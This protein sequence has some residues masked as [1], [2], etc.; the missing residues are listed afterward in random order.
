M[1]LTGSHLGRLS[2]CR[3]AA[4]S[5]AA[6]AAGS[7]ARPSSSQSLLA[8]GSRR[9][10]P[11]RLAPAR[12]GGGGQKNVGVYFRYEEVGGDD[13]DDDD[14]E[15]DEGDDETGECLC[16]E[17]AERARVRTPFRPG[18]LAAAPDA[19]LGGYAIGAR[20]A[21]RAERLPAHCR[22]W[23]LSRRCGVS[24]PSRP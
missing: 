12:A 16:D 14:G 10:A 20:A 4:P 24:S 1:L 3:R 23:R 18:G 6:A 2:A 9:R 21:T 19:E 15:D 11:S 8:V 22:P 7:G 5:I 17:E 13:E